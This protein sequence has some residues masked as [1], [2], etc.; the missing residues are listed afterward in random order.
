M[1]EHDSACAGRGSSESAVPSVEGQRRARSRLE[2]VKAGAGAQQKIP[3]YRQ[4]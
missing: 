2:T 4:G 3:G 1:D